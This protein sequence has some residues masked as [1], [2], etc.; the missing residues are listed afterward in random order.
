M[1]KRI[2]VGIIGLG[3]VGGAV[4]KWFVGNK[5]LYEVF[6]YDKYKNI[7]SIKEV[8]RAD[9]IFVA[10]PTPF[11]PGK[12]YDDS[13]VREAIAN[14]RDGAV[15]VIKSTVMPR[16]TERFQKQYPKKTILFN[17]EFLRAKTAA[18]DF[19]HPDRQLVGYGAPKGKGAAKKVLAILPRAPYE[20]IMKA[21]EAE[22]VKYFG[23]AFLSARVIFANQIYDICTAAG[24]DY[25]AVK[26]A[27]SRDPRV[28]PSHFTIFD[29]GYRGYGGLCLPKDVNALIQF[30]RSVRADLGLLRSLEKINKKLR[31]LPTLK[32]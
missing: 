4:N 21:R 23:N 14:V 10:V 15:I 17:P 13:A 22:M 3:Y 5:A 28:G 16:S 32:Q 6:R 9:I 1:K 31:R 20:K 11:T 24:I 7:G 2:K 30:G 18:K 26:E 8:N 12:G 25:E 27:A 29:E 19:L